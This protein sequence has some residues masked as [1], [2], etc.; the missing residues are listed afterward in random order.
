MEFLFGILAWLIFAIFLSIHL[1]V[2]R[3]REELESRWIEEEDVMRGA[4]AIRVN[5][6]LTECLISLTRQ[7]A[8]AYGPWIPSLLDGGYNFTLYKDSRGR[9]SAERQHRVVS[10]NVALTAVKQTI[11]DIL[12]A[13]VSYDNDGRE[14]PHRVI[15]LET[16][17]GAERELLEMG[18]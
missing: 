3:K 9:V 2:K 16:L 5:Q 8:R 17:Y 7:R 13:P 1:R 11:A 10:P 6:I 18:A 4:I 15:D 14:M 12:A